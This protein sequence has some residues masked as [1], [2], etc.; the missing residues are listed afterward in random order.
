[1]LRPDCS[2][3]SCCLLMEGGLNCG[4]LVEKVSE[5][6]IGMLPKDYPCDIFGKECGCSLPLFRKTCGG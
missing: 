6:N 5:E 2:V 3:S 1:M 4:G